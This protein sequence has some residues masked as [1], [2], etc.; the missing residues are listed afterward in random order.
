[1]CRWRRTVWQG[2]SLI[3]DNTLILS[4]YSHFNATSFVEGGETVVMILILW[5]PN[6]GPVGTDR[7]LDRVLQT[8]TFIVQ[9]TGFG[10]LRSQ[11]WNFDSL[12]RYPSVL[13]LL[14]QVILYYYVRQSNCWLSLKQ[15]WHSDALGPVIKSCHSWGDIFRF[16]DFIFYYRIEISIT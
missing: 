11:T 8:K 1:M 14:D 5:I 10:V 9:F 7:D 16:Q 3:T 6:T 12:H 13:K 4:T 15:V 2:M